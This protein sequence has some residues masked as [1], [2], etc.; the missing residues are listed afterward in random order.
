[1]RSAITK[2]L[3]TPAFHCKLTTSLTTMIG[4]SAYWRAATKDTQKKISR[5]GKQL[6]VVQQRKKRQRTC[7]N[8]GVVMVSLRGGIFHGLVF[9]SETFKPVDANS[10]DQL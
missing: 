3:C 8:R 10:I 1:M 6:N 7:E 5:S 2:R 9:R 4:L